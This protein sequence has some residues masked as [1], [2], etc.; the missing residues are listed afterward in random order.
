MNIQTISPADAK[1]LIDQGALLVDIREA[2][3]HARERIAGSR[4]HPVDCLASIDSVAKPVVF[5]CRSGHR[6]GA[7]AAK[8][9]AATSCD[10]YILDGGI[11]NWKRNGLP[12]FADRMQPLELRRQ[13]QIAAG[14]L[15]LVGIVLGLLVDPRFVGLSAFIGAGLTFAGITGWCGMAKVFAV[16]PWNRRSATKV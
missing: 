4:N 15:V 14:S 7:N 16:M 1:R 11:E 3:E 8:L 2:D 12:V 5:H 6:T 13:V 9:A 10:A